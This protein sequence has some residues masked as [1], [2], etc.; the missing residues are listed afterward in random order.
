MGHWQEPLRYANNSNVQ[1]NTKIIILNSQLGIKPKKET[2]LLITRRIPSM[3]PSHQDH[4]LIILYKLLCPHHIMSMILIAK[5]I[6]LSFKVFGYQI[7]FGN[8][9]ISIQ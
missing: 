6:L 3:D 7:I 2:L 4:H 8:M 9:L 1:S 5:T